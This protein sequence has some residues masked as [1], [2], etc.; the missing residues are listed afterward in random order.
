M[1]SSRTTNIE[2]TTRAITPPPFPV[3][4]RLG[5][6]STRGTPPWWNRVGAA[7]PNLGHTPERARRRSVPP[8]A[9]TP[10]RALHGDLGRRPRR[11]AGAHLRGTAPGGSGGPGAPHRRD[12]RGAPGVGVRRRA[13]HPGRHE[14]GGGAPAGDLR[15]RALPVRPD[16]AGLLRRRRPCPRHG[17]QRRLGLG[18]L[19]V[20][21]HGL[22]RSGLLRRQ[23]PRCSA[24]PAS[25]PG[26]TG[27]SR[28]GTRGIP[29]A[30]SR[31]G[32]RIWPTPTS[33]SPRSAATPTAASHR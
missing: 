12:A 3:S 18:E 13:L 7:R 2:T 16:A 26:T 11:G 30:S 8:R 17:H 20:H 4:F 6:V 10:G 31:S 23:G 21:D 22:L 32:S 14:R 19:P 9:R 28:S 5:P 33:P 27:S 29:S 1:P 25:G 24:W 15:A